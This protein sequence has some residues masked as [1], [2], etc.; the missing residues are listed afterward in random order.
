MHTCKVCGYEITWAKVGRKQKLK[1]FHQAEAGFVYVIA[2]GGIATEV[3]AYVRH[4]HT[5]DELAEVEQAI[6][7]ERE[8]RQEQYFEYE[9]DREAANELAKKIDCPK[10]GVVAGEPCVNLVK[11]KKGEHVETRWPHPDRL[12]ERTETDL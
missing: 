8:A 6:Q 11:Q 5:A 7:A 2:R 1:P 12:P 9:S 10:C 4:K 3:P